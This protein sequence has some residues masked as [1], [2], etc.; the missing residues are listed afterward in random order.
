MLMGYVSKYKCYLEIL[1]GIPYD[2][3]NIFNSLL[4]NKDANGVCFKSSAFKIANQ[5]E[6]IKL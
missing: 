6:I 3:N 2:S 1:S 4:F 5:I